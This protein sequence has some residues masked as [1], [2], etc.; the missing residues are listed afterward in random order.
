MTVENLPRWLACISLVFAFAASNSWAEGVGAWR[1]LGNAVLLHEQ[2][3][4][5]WTKS[6][7]GQDL[8][9]DDAKAYCAQFGVGWRLPHAEELTNLHADAQ[10]KGDSAAC[11]NATCQIPPLFKLS[12]NWYWSGTEVTQDTTSRAHILAWGVLLVNGR[13]TQ[14][15][16]FMP[17]G[18]RALCVQVPASM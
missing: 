2:T 18:A 11:G 13:Q 4:L 15:F 5:R 1:Y 9:W 8:N 12:G 10:R 7:N 6:D 14:T 17:H 16:K 3:Q